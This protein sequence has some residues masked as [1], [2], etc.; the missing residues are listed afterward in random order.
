MFDLFAKEC[1]E[2]WLFENGEKDCANMCDEVKE[3]YNTPHQTDVFLKTW[4]LIGSLT[5]NEI[6]ESPV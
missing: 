2:H 3:M 5:N 1:V 4:P 6:R